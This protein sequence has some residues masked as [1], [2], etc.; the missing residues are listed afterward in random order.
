[1]AAYEWVAEQSDQE[2]MRDRARWRL[3]CTARQL[4][5]A[6]AARATG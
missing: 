3:W 4:A 1:M 5:A 2:T 6:H